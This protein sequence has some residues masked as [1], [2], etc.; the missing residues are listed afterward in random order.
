[1][2]IFPVSVNSWF[3]R[4][5]CCRFTCQYLSMHEKSTFDC[6]AGL[7]PASRETIRR[8]KHK[9]LYQHSCV[10]C[11]HSSVQQLAFHKQKKHK[12]GHAFTGSR[13]P[14][15]PSGLP[16]VACVCAGQLTVKWTFDFGP[17]L[18]QCRV[19]LSETATTVGIL[20]LRLAASTVPMA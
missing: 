4:S 8:L 19:L 3:I 16:N 15:N 9:L 2:R 20:A 13:D 7:L 10:P 5:A 11:V 14:G 1:M 6:F 17:S 18:H 12:L